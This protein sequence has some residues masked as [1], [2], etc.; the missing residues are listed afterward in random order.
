MPIKYC[1]GHIDEEVLNSSDGEFKTYLSVNLTE[2][3]KYKTNTKYPR[4]FSNAYN[5]LCFC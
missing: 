4:D 3:R 5:V 2:L 1:T